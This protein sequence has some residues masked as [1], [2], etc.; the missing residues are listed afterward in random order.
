MEL[1][2]CQIH[3]LTALGF[4]VV[5]VFIYSLS[6]CFAVDRLFTK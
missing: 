5:V 6:P 4:V 3:V 1:M 2:P